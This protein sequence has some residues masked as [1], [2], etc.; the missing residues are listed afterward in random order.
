MLSL[1]CLFCRTAF[2]VLGL[3]ASTR[4]GTEILAKYGWES[5]C[6]TRED[7]WP[8][9]DEGGCYPFQYSNYLA[10]S[11][12]S[13]HSA[14]KADGDRIMTGSTQLSFIEEEGKGD[15]L[16]QNCSCDKTDLPARKSLNIP[17][18]VNNRV[19]VPFQQ[20][21]K[22]LPSSRTLQAEAVEFQR[23][24]S[25]KSN[26][27]TLNAKSQQVTHAETVNSS[28]FGIDKNVKTTSVATTV[29]TNLSKTQNQTISTTDN[30]VTYVNQ[31]Q[32]SESEMSHSDHRKENKFTFTV[33]SMSPDTDSKGQ[34]KFS[35]KLGG[36][37]VVR[38]DRSS[39]EGS[40]KSK[41][42]TSSFNTD[43]TTSGISSCDSGLMPTLTVSPLSPI[44]SASSLNT[45]PVSVHYETTDKVHPSTFNR[46]LVNLTRVPSLRR[47]SA[48][49][50]PNVETGSMYTSYRDAVGYA[51]LRIIK[52]QRTYSSEGEGDTPTSLFAEPLITRTCST[53]SDSSVDNV[54]LRCVL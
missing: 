13:F 16:D 41:S 26:S 46:R 33:G 32:G 11:C 14:F 28:S 25:V 2:Y 17:I 21:L 27:E 36:N 52:R 24:H 45:I 8:V 47:R 40:H 38:E 43:S 29:I 5:M 12:S 22:E 42:R 50:N 18:L 19:P 20:S 9:L 10:D 23:F 4:K 1:L 3:L 51:T 48:G 53:E 31:S 15:N 30:G 39:S 34:E 37:S 54:Y 44:A 49:I 35:F 7:L 6:R